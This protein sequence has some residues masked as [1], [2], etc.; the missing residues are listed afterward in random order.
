MRSAL[1]ATLVV[2]AAACAPP[3]PPAASPPVALVQSVYERALS[4]YPGAD[5]ANRAPMT[6]ELNALLDQASAADG[7]ILDADPVMDAND[8]ST[9]EHLVVSEDA[10]AA[11]GHVTV[12]AH[13]TQAN[14]PTVVHYDLVE[15][16][17]A[18]LIDNI[19]SDRGA[20]LRA[21]LQAGLAAAATPGAAAT[22]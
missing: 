7:Q 8:P 12:T 2:L 4:A 5:V 3:A 19:R 13:F 6:P 15:R 18:W 20:D 10:P 14:E 17:G 22:P 1:I 11:G 9:P 16:D 21:N